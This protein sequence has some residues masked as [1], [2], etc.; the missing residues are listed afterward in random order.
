MASVYHTLAVQCFVDELA[1][2]AGRDSVEYLLDL[3]GPPRVLNLKIPIY[4]AEP[5]FPL[6]IGR[7][8]RV[9]EMAAEKAGWGKRTLGKGVGL[10]IA[11]HRYAYTYVASVVEVEV[12]ESGKIRIPRIDTAVDGGHRNQSC[13]HT[14]GV[15]RICCVR[16]QYC[17]NW[18]DYCNQWRHRPVEL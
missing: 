14:S 8:R 9:T 5:A 3:F 2:S 11:A 1:H 16:N 18:S 6:D 4:R 12:S 10:G 7:L 13:Q 17:S 15:R